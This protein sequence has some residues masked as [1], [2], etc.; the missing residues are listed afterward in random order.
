MTR[1]GVVIICHDAD[2]SR[3]GEQ[4]LNLHE[5]Y[6]KD[7]PLYR[8]KYA[9]GLINEHIFESESSTN[10]CSLEQLFELL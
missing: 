6:F 9:T 5:C 8:K 2:L 3:V 7:L 4:S 1:D 10:F